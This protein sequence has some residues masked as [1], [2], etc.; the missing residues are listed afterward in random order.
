M[1][2]TSSDPLPWL[3]LLVILALAIRLNRL[4]FDKSKRLIQDWA[5]K[6]D[7]Q[8]F[9]IQQRYWRR[10]PFTWTSSNTQIVCFVVLRC[11]QRRRTA[12]IRCGGYLLGTLSDDIAVRWD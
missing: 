8:V 2:G 4:A 9:S 11:Q 3:L 10:G 7:C 12:Y 1:T 6:N 5:A